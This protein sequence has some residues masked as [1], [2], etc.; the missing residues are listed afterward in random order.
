M[1][2]H[3]LQH[4]AFEGIGSIAA[5]AE[6]KGF[7]LSFTRLDCGQPLPVGESFDLL[8]VMGGP[9]S[10]DE[11]EAYPWLRAEKQ[12][13]AQAIRQGKKVLGICLGAQLIAAVLGGKVTRN[14][15]KEIGWFPVTLTEEARRAPLW[16][17][18]PRVF[19]AFHWHG[20]TFSIPPGCVKIAA[21]EACADQAFVLDSRVVGLQ[22]HLEATEQSV[23]ALLKHCRADLTPGDY[24]QQAAAIRAQREYFPVIRGLLFGL[25]D[26]LVE[27]ENQ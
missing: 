13:I 19:P 8:I 21:S 23:D 15:Y 12:L 6:A 3:V 17:H 10:V 2:I 27:C 9:M 1:N 22:F 11:E 24:V 5:W 18:F 26:R 7:S 16:R 14:R 25:L 4:V 20:D